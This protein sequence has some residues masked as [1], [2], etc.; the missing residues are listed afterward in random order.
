MAKQEI[1][2]V[3]VEI[4][5]KKKGIYMLPYQI[6]QT[7]KEDYPE[8]WEVIKTTYSAEYGKGAGVHYT[9]ATFIAKKLEVLSR[10]EPNIKEATL[11]P[12]GIFINKVEPSESQKSLSIFCIK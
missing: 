6:C 5:T 2:K 9:I 4:L 8:T 12:K 7:L 1:E 11:C 3:L 10:K